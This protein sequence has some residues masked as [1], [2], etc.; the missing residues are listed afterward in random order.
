[1]I[2]VLSP[3]SFPLKKGFGAAWRFS[4][5]DGDSTSMYHLAYFIWRWCWPAVVSLGISWTV[6]AFPLHLLGRGKALI[7][8]LI[9]LA[10]GALSLTARSVLQ[11]PS[12]SCYAAGWEKGWEGSLSPLSGVSHQERLILSLSSPQSKCSRGTAEGAGA[13]SWPNAPGGD[14][15]AEGAAEQNGEGEEHWDW[16][17]AGQVGLGQGWVVAGLLDPHVRAGLRVQADALPLRPLGRQSGVDSEFNLVKGVTQV[18]TN[19]EFWRRLLP[20]YQNLAPLGT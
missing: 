15:E 7:R 14:Q 6:V 11:P 4:K 8:L 3:S 1:M 13:E 19:P 12:P 16:E 20:S 10:M 9:E 2:P 17:P 5:L 18:I